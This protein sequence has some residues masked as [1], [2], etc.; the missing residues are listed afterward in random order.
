MPPQSVKEEIMKIYRPR[1]L[2]TYWRGS[3][4]V[5]V[6]RSASTSPPGPPLKGGVPGS[7]EVPTTQRH[8]AA[9]K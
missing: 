6:A 9:A 4:E 7:G 8:P 3:G 2:A 5:K 1:H